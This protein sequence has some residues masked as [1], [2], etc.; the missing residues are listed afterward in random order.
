MRRYFTYSVDEVDEM[1]EWKLRLYL[2]ELDA[3]RRAEAGMEPIEHV[4]DITQV[5]DNKI[6]SLVTVRHMGDD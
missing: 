4:A 1:E 6:L 2:E 3:E 5:Q